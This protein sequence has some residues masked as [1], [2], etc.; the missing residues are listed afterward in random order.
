[1]ITAFLV[2]VFWFSVGLMFHSYILFPL[3]LELFSFGKKDNEIVYSIG[4][5]Q[6][7][8]VYV[9][10]SVYNEEKVIRQKLESIF[11]TSYPLEKLSILIGSDNS[12]DKTNSIVAEFI[13]KYPALTFISFQERSGKSSVL[14]KLI[15]SLN[16]KIDKQNDVFIFTDANVIFTPETIFELVKHFRNEN[17]S[18]VGANILNHENTRNGISLQEKFYISRENAIKYLEGVNWGSMM[19]AFG[20]CYAL[21]ADCWAEIPKNYLMEDFYLS[22]NVLARNRKAILELK[23]I[24]YEDVSEEMT[25]EF[26]RK[27]RIQAGNFQNLQVYRQLL[28][29]VD[30]VSFCFLSHKVIRWFG[31]LLICFTYVSN[32][33]LL[34]QPFY[35]FTFLIQNLRSHSIVPRIHRQAE[36]NIRFVGIK[37]LLLQL[38]CF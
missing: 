4:D 31:P 6:L 22:M 10:F 37:S 25:E 11:N 2:V 32:I 28:F 34:Q 1:M 7:P 8:E 24:C 26:K 15:S 13:A 3:L 9:I 38:I 36:L 16:G 23:A 5:P 19:G 20:A 12:T 18:Q 14:N 27:S 33:F 30:A 35:Q 29:R 21:R 17:I